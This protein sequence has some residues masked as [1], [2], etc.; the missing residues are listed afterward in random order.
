MESTHHNVTVAKSVPLVPGSLVTMDRGYNDYKLL[1]Y[2][3]SS[4]IFFVTRL[5]ENADYMIVE[6]LPIPIHRNIVSD[7]LIRLTGF[8][9]QKHRPY[10]L[11]RSWR[12]TKTRSKNILLT[13]CPTFVATTISAVYKY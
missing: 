7:H 6:S 8:Y 1:A 3:S 4:G 12:R 5:K 9:A 11:Q 2:W 13:N 10:I